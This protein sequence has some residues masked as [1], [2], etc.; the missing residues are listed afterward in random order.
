[1]MFL[2]I[3]H[4]SYLLASPEIKLSC[5]YSPLLTD[6]FQEEKGGNADFMLS[7]LNQNFI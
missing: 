5:F 1:M 2:R 7:S 6:S 4:F 3:E